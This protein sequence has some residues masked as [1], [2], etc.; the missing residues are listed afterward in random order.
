MRPVYHQAARGRPPRTDDRG[1]NA[2][3]K[4]RSAADHPRTIGP[5]LRSIRPFSP[6]RERHPLF[7]ALLRAG[8]NIF[9]VSVLSSPAD[10]QPQTST[11]RVHVIGHRPRASA[12]A[13]LCSCAPSPPRSC[14]LLVGPGVLLHPGRAVVGFNP[15]SDFQIMTWSLAWWPW[16][17]APRR[18]SAA[19]EPAL[20]AAGLLD[21]VDDDDP[22][23]GPARRPLTLA[24]GPL[25]SYNV[26]MLLAA[27]PRRRSRLPALPRAERQLP[28]LAGR[29]PALR[30]LALHAGAHCSRST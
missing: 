1:S 11:A 4:G 2:R 18:R 28:C 25:V 7:G 14:V 8:S 22:G 12:A 3:R 15:A 27:A 21:A 13:K 29:R 20:A 17:L 19:H 16:A 6:S 24:A 30:A 23:A 5:G 9:A 10:S 26:L